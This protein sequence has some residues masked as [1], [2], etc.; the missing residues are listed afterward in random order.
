M[1]A[2]LFYLLTFFVCSFTFSQTTE[3]EDAL[4]TVHTDTID[5]WKFNGMATLNISQVGLTNWAA[6]GFNSL[7]I[8][9][10][11]NLNLD[12]KKGP[13]AWNN[14]LNLG[15]GVIR[16]GRLSDPK[17]GSFVKTDDKI[18]LFSKYG[19]KATEK[20]YYAGLIN[21]TTQSTAGFSYPNDS[22]IISKFMAP[23]YLLIALGMDYKPNEVFSAFVAP[24]TAKTTI[25][26]D[27]VLANEGAY[28]VEKATFDLAGNMLT[29]GKKVRMEYGGYVRLTYKKS[30][31]E[32]VTLTSKLSL[33]SNYANRP[34]N[35]DVNWENLLEFKVNKF[36]SATLSTQLIYDH[37]I[38]ITDAAG[39]VGPR[40]QFKEVLGIGFSYKF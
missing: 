16:Q 26:N 39:K 37:D 15:Y 2:G 28:G 5:G 38:Q 36:I 12:Y 13:S 11:I 40:T 29:V 20:W 14:T 18:D 27:V 6:G 17:S 8:N 32:N 19:R 23:A 30:F 9:G 34:Q 1:K 21:F 25:V 35:I 10:L 24:L 31:M 7:A 33:F 22:V 3:K 4:K